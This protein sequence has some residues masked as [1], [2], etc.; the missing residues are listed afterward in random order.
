[1]ENELTASFPVLGIAAWSGTGKTTLLEKLLPRLGEYGLNVAV[2]KHAHHSFDVDQPGKDSYKLRS[3]GAAPVLVA[4]RQRFALM[5]ETPGQDE[6]DL[7][8]LIAMMVPHKP[9]LVIVEGFKA[10]PI[11]KL[12][13]YRD[14]IGDAAI[15]TGQW[16]EAVALSAPPPI[17]LA[18]S[19]AQLDLDDSEA[20]AQWV[21]TWLSAK[22][23]TMSSKNTSSKQ[24]W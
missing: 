8:Q 11:P 23:D 3:A 14:G 17:D 12:V 10:W 4:S 13:L 16:V 22:N 1:M 15:L 18:A 21:V 5:Q 24:Q 20:V 9:D 7:G 2:I 6:P 19:V